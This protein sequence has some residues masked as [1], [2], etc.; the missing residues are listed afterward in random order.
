MRI[1]KTGRCVF[2]RKIINPQKVFLELESNCPFRFCRHIFGM[3]IEHFFNRVSLKSDRSKPIGRKDSN[4][5]VNST[6]SRSFIR[7]LITLR[8]F[9]VKRLKTFILIILKWRLKKIWYFSQAKFFY[10]L[11]YIYDDHKRKHFDKDCSSNI[12]VL[13]GYLSQRFP[14]LELAVPGLI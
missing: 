8:A 13:L 6:C 10:F 14:I 5:K 7:L 3:C 12:F 11:L 2:G 1:L 9:S 4:S